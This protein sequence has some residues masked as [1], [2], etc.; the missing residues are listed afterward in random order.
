M[1]KFFL[2][3][4]LFLYF[5]LFSCTVIFPF[6]SFVV[7]GWIRR[8]SSTTSVRM[9]S[10]A[11]LRFLKCVRMCWRCASKPARHRRHRH[12]SRPRRVHKKLFMNRSKRKNLFHSRDLFVAFAFAYFWLLLFI[13]IFVIKTA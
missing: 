12:F 2:R 9:S 13:F 6:I 8:R 5:S 1:K 10:R 4:T 11:S 3:K 7:F